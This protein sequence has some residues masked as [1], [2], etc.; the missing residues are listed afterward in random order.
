MLRTTGT[1]QDTVDYGTEHEYYVGGEVTTESHLVTF[2]SAVRTAI[3]KG[4]QEPVTDKTPYFLAV[5]VQ[6]SRMIH[7][8]MLLHTNP[9]YSLFL[10]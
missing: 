3:L 8:K 6:I 9:S 1:R 7:M 4:K 5:I 10:L 2:G